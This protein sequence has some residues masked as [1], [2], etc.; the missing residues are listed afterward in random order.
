MAS[1]VIFVPKYDEWH[2]IRWAFAL[3]DLVEPEYMATGASVYRATFA[4]WNVTFC[5]M[6]EQNTTRA[7]VTTSL[8]LDREKPDYAFLAGTALGRSPSVSIGSV[9]LSTDGVHDLVERRIE[10]PAGPE[11]AR[12]A[13]SPYTISSPVALAMTARDFITTHF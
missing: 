9:V 5:L 3:E 12:Y 8:V 2:A 13:Y 4:D 1:S 7:A 11:T 6:N 10:Q